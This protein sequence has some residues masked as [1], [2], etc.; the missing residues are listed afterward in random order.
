MT[1]KKHG[2][3]VRIIAGDFRGR[4]LPVTSLDGLRP[5]TD[6][7]RET[8]FNWLMH[9]VRGSR[10]LDLFAGSGALGFECL[11]RGAARVDFVELD[12]RVAKQIEANIELLK[13]SDRAQV[14]NQSADAFLRRKVQAPYDLVFIDPPFARGE[15]LNV[16]S[17]LNDSALIS[18]Q[19]LIYLES[20]S[21]DESPAVPDNWSIWRQGKAGASIYTL[22][23]TANGD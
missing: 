15:L 6:R 8:L 19:S 17:N 18:N 11:S 20:P 1:I 23:E 13:V 2:N 3:S 22:F 4:R 21:A 7:V 12:R 9:E 10:C 5:T 14:W 16:V